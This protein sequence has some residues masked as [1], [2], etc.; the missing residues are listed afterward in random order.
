MQYKNHIIIVCL[1]VSVVL[2]MVLLCVLLK[3]NHD[4]NSYEGTWKCTSNPNYEI[5]I[6]VDHN[7]TFY[8]ALEPITPDA[9]SYGITVT[10]NLPFLVYKGYIEKSSLVYKG[11]KAIDGDDH[12]EYLSDIPNDQYDAVNYFYTIIR[13]SENTLMIEIPGDSRTKYTFVKTDV[14][15]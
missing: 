13:N 8:E 2:N 1:V 7:G 11:V 10:N 14:Q 4:M 3:N 15:G 6:F 9:S 5:T 12:Y